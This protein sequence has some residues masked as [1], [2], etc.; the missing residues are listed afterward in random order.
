[1]QTLAIL[2]HRG[3][4]AAAATDALYDPEAAADDE[5]V[6]ALGPVAEAMF[7]SQQ[8]YL[9]CCSNSYSSH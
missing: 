9:I 6:A 1:M 5:T 7:D 4:I 2:L 3:E 8:W